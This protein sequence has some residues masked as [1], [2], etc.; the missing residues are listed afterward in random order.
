MRGFSLSFW[1]LLLGW[2]WW[3]GLGVQSFLGPE[4]MAIA[5]CW[6]AGAERSDNRKR[7]THE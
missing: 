3:H 5:G 7:M 1:A 4:L 6:A 2:Q